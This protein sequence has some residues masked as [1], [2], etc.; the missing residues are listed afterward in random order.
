[1][2]RRCSV[3]GCR[4]N[5]LGDTYTKVIAFPTEDS[6][7]ERWMMAMPNVIKSLR[8]LKQNYVYEKHFRDGCEWK[9]VRGGRRPM[10]PPSVFSE[11]ANS[12]L[13]QV[14]PVRRATTRSSAD[15]RAAKVKKAVEANDTIKDFDD[16]VSKLIPILNILLLYTQRKK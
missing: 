7:K 6:E 16:F 13:K 2:P 5:Y 3:F 4:G 12:S 1:M 10:E 9:T 15:E 11:V 8:G 14:I